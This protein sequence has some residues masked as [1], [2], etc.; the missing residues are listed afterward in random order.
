ML[1]F[2]RLFP[3]QNILLDTESVS[4]ESG[5]KWK[6]MISGSDSSLTL[7]LLTHKKQSSCPAVKL[8][9]N[10]EAPSYNLPAVEQRSVA[11]ATSAL[12]A[13]SL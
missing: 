8:N 12:H 11:I 3:L 2:L 7:L 6:R 13:N 4:V 1:G 10:T 5:D 9:R